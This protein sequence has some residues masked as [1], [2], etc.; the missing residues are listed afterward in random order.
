MI[1]RAN[2]DEEAESQLVVARLVHSV[3]NDIQR[4]AYAEEMR[5][6]REEAEGR[7]VVAHLVS[8]A[9][10]TVRRAAYAEQAADLER[11]LMST[12]LA[13]SAVATARAQESVQAERRLKQVSGRVGCKA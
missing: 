5:T 8:T 10:D 2:A 4:A 11:K 1:G 3:F 9:F 7:M 12:C 6:Q 13:A